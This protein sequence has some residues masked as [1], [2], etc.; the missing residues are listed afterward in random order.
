MLIFRG[1]N[2]VTFKVEL[3]V[4]SSSVVLWLGMWPVTWGP[5]VYLIL[6]LW[7]LRPKQRNR[8]G[9]RVWLSKTV[10]IRRLIFNSSYLHDFS[11]YPL[12]RSHCIFFHLEKGDVSSTA[13][14]NLCLYFGTHTSLHSNHP[15]IR[16]SCWNQD[17][18]GKLTNSF[19]QPALLSQGFS[20][21]PGVKPVTFDMPILSDGGNKQS[22]YGRAVL[23]AESSEEPWRN[24]GP[25]DST[26]SFFQ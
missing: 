4:T 14:L 11:G 1:V 24:R 16:Y 15:L 6:D 25:S 17:S 5:F 19:S 9:T 3:H 7:G 10:K 2:H 8:R 21:S 23:P 13:L 26:F 12:S 18:P 22:A 20:D